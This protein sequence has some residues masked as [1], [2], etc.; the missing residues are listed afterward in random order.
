MH[1]VARRP[2]RKFGLNGFEPIASEGGGPDPA[3]ESL[4]LANV[5]EPRDAR[6]WRVRKF[7]PAFEFT[8]STA[9]FS[10]FFQ[11]LRARKER[12]TRLLE[13][14]RLEQES[15]KRSACEQRLGL[16]SALG[17]RPMNGATTLAWNRRAQLRGNRLR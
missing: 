17:Q 16:S 13:V 15:R 5:I 1:R 11:G 10:A 4:V 7:E 2:S 6:K 14:P 8:K 3:R 9:Y 12:L